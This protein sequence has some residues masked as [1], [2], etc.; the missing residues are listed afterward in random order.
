MRINNAGTEVDELGLHRIVH[1][2]GETLIVRT[3]TFQSTFLLE[4]VKTYIISIVC[5]TTTEVDIVVLTNTSLKHLIHPFRIGVV[6]EF[7]CAITNCAISGRQR[8]T[9]VGCCLANI[10]AILISIHHII[11]TLADEVNTKVTL[12]VNLQRLILLTSLGC[13]D[14]HTVSSTRTVDSTGR[15]IFQHLNGLN[16]V[17]REVAN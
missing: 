17:W 7:I 14:N 6:H 9:R 1:T 4:V 3:C 10:C 11:F 16:V 2:G 8:C 13:D 12:I 15:S 5:T